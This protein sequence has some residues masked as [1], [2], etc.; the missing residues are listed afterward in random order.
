VQEPQSIDKEF[1]RLW[2]RNNCDPYKDKHLPEAPME[3]V[4]ELS[5]RYIHLFETITGQ[6]FELP[7]LGADIN[8]RM[9]SNIE[10]WVASS[11]IEL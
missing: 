6:D 4:V 1:L 5:K 9:Q 2:F 8:D 11:G 3:L 7:A 10:K